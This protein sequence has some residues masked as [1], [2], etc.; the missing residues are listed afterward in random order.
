MGESQ[1][2]DQHGHDT[3]LATRHSPLAVGESSV[4]ATEEILLAQAARGDQDAFA[5]LYDRTAGIVYGVIRRVLRDPAQSE[6]VTQEVLVEVWRTATRF[7]T[8][9]GCARTWMLTMARRRAIDR[10]RSEQAS[11]NRTMS[12]GSCQV[13]R[14]FD[15]VAEQVEASAE[16]AQVRQSLSA[17]SDLQREAI[18]LAYVHGYTYRQ[19]AGLLET[20]LGTIKTRIRDGLTRLRVAMAKT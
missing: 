7:D 10:V 9:R 6:E 17:L 13:S 14:A 20:P 4:P 15:E 18:E 3:M 19:I 12:L 2:D 16:H 1:Q 11:R 5:E 8:G